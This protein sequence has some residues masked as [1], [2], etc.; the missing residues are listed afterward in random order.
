MSGRV[1]D[2]CELAPTPP[3]CR[4]SSRGVMAGLDPRH[5]LRQRTPEVDVARQCVHF[6][7]VDQDLHGRDR[8]QV[9]SDRVDEGVDREDFVERSARMIRGRLRSRGPRKPALSLM[10]TSF[11]FVPSGLPRRI[12]G[13]G[14][15]SCASTIARAW[16]AGSAPSALP[17]L[18][19]QPQAVVAQVVEPGLD[20][21]RARRL[22]GTGAA[23]V[24][25]D[26]SPASG[27]SSADASSAAGR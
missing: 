5:V 3:A 23:G 9:I 16:A 1:R 2:S 21:R 7:A 26:G 27:R 8:R 25:G 11:S 22:A 18:G 6:V 14:G 24:A 20:A 13:G 10:K 15:S 12:R 4:L 19:L 17:F